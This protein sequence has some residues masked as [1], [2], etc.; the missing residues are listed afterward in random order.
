MKSSLVPAVVFVDFVT[1]FPFSFTTRALLIVSLFPFKS[2]G[3][4][5]QI[6]D[7]RNPKVANNKGIS[8]MV[9]LALFSIRFTSSSEGIYSSFF[10]F[11]EGLYKY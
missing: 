11:A 8:Y 2:S 9:P 1:K 5:A 10:A 3:V 4:R 6:S 7:R